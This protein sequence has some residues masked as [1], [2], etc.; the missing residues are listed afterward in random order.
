M[1]FIFGFGKL[2]RVWCTL[3]SLLHCVFLG[4]F[5]P[6]VYSQP[7]S[8]RPPPFPFLYILL[9]TDKKKIISQRHSVRLKQSL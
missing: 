8:P 3:L 4:S 6:I 2:Y 9:L 5:V 7:P 1:G